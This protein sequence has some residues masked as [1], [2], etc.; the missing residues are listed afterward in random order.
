MTRAHVLGSAEL[1]RFDQRA[2]DLILEAMDA[3]WVGYI[4]G[5]NHAILYAPD[6]RGSLSVSR[7]SKRGRSGRN[8]EAA[9]RRWERRQ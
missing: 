3:G 6:G 7:D 1:G 4:S 5:R 8:A 9:Y 2:T